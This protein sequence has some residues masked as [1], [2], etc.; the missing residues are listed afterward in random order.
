[1]SMKIT[2]REFLAR[3]V[4]TGSAVAAGHLAGP[5]VWAKQAATVK[6]PNLLFIMSDEHSFD[7]LGCYATGRSTHPTST[8][9]PPPASASATAS[10]TTPSVHPIAA[11]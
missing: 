9:P 6:R 3:S 7:M 2:R 5:R 8:G 4:A 11:S 1:M 10:A